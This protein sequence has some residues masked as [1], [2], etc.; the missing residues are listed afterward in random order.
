MA[1]IQKAWLTL[2]LAAK[3]AE[4]IESITIKL[5]RKI[6]EFYRSIFGP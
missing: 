2:D 1:S 5:L 4:I 6:C 3:Y